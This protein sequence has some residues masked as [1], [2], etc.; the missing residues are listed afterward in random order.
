MRKVVGLLSIAFLL[1]SASAAAVPGG[2]LLEVQDLLQI[3]EAGDPQPSPDGRWVA[4]T[5]RRAVEERDTNETRIWMVGAEGGDAVPM[6]APGGDAYRPR[7]SPDGRHLAFLADRGKKK[8]QV[9]TLFRHGGEAV[10]LT[11]VAQ[12]IESFE[13]SPDGKKLVL[14]VRDAE[15]DPAKQA[16]KDDT[17]RPWVLDRRQFKTDGV[18]YLDERRTHLYVFD[19][20][21]KETKQITSGPYDDSEPAFSPDGRWIVFTSNRTPDPDANYNTDLWVVAA[22]SGEPRRL[23]SNPGIDATPAWSADGERIVYLAT[24]DMPV[25]HYAVSYLATV[26]ATGAD[27]RLL[28]EEIDRNVFDPRFSADGRFVYFVLEDDGEQVLSRLPSS[29]VGDLERLVGGRDVVTGFALGPEKTLTLTVSRPHLPTEVFRFRE[30]EL[31]QLSHTNAALLGELQLGEVEE[32]RFKSRDGTSI[33]GFLVK[34]P[35]FGP[36]RRYPTLLRMHGGPMGQYDG[37]FDFEKQLF[38]AHGYV[39]VMPN[40]RGSSGYG[41]EFGLAIW[42]AW[43]EDDYEDVMAAVDDA[44][45]R[46]YADPE[47][48]GVGGHSY[49]GMMTNHVI[50]KTGRFQAAITEAGATLYVSN[51]G[52]DQYQRWWE[53]ELGLPWKD[54]E[55]WE[56]LSPFNRVEHVTTPTLVVCGEKDWNVPVINSEQLYQALKRLGIDT[57]LVVY[58]GESHS[59]ERPSYR[60]D[61]FERSLGWYD[62][63][64]L[65]S[66][67]RNAE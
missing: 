63:Y 3:G 51:F 12:G 37:R 40:P 66:G 45:E 23:T 4:Y 2:R 59:I 27:E 36:G 50:T 46:G 28:R 38:A 21:S 9:Y 33:E 13:Y 18:G 16:W 55:L 25:A 14:V 24:K 64:V 48:L 39:V 19:V 65:G 57:R 54:R 8:T 5:V 52:H 15:P 47:R 56:K 20:A 30:G 10:R 61:L 44:V 32:V 31:E 26:S 49:G 6:T 29:G 11:D 1:A 17:P 34:P 41:Q 62:R 53:G 7:W 67:A 42:Q 43:G 35:D 22:A 58:P 60:I